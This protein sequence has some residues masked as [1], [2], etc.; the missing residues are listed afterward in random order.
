MDPIVDLKN[1]WAH[2]EDKVVLESVNLVVE[3]HDFLGIIGPNGG[4]KTTLL[5]II[6]GLIKSSRGEVK[7]FGK[8]PQKNRHLIGYVPQIRQF[9]LEFPATVWDVVATGRLGNS[10]L[11]RRYD[12]E[13][14]KI[15]KE[16]LEEV[17]MI[18]FRDDAIGKLSGG[19]R[20][21]VLIAR[22]LA[23]NPKLLLLDEPTTNVDKNLDTKLWEFFNSL[24]KKITIVLVTHDISAVSVYVDKIACLNRK[25]YYQGTKEITPEMW[26]E[27]YKCPVDM[28]AH[29]L[30]H[31]VLEEH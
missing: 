26:T 3:E 28:I 24:K 16:A 7:V 18:E 10:K 12:Y 2:Y 9:D 30:P 20:Q 6:L 31:R 8:S 22:A 17:D 19:E 29:G 4:G 25:L 1:V 15:V 27:A 11:S 5:K 14:R 23:S 13:D 21:R